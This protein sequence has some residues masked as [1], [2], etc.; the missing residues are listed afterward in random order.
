MISPL[1]LFLL[2]L[3]CIVAVVGLFRPFVGLLVF[4]A[5]H[6]V[7]PAEMLPALAPL[8]I[9]MVYAALLI[10]L[11][12]FRRRDAKERSPFF[13]DHV[14]RGAFV[15][16]GAAVLSVPFALWIGGALATVFELLK[17]I[18]LMVLIR[19]MVDTEDRLRG[20]LWCMT[21]IGAW[22]ASSSLSAF[23]N[24]NYYH[25][26]YNLGNLN[27]AQGVNSIVGG[28]NELAGALLALLPLLIALLSNTRSWLARLLLIVCGAVS[29]AAIALTGSRIAI[30]GLLVIGL[31][32]ACLSKHRVRVV[33]AIMLIGCSLWIWMPREYRQRYLTVEEYAEGAKLDDS[34]ELRFK[35]WAAGRDIF[36]QRPILGVGAGQFSTGYGLLILRGRHLAW[37][38]PHNL[39]IQVACELGLVGVF[40]FGYFLVQISKAIATVLRERDKSAVRMNYQVGLACTVMFVGVLTLSAA[41]HTL[42]RPYWYLLGGMVAAN[43]NLLRTKLKKASSG[44]SIDTVE[45]ES[46]ETFGHWNTTSKANGEI[47]SFIAQHER[48][49]RH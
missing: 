37:M 42:Y 49:R 41:G 1:I 36:L 33:L 31:F 15:L 44:Q 7:Q 12:T 10:G 48:R 2:L 47:S 35:I 22:F 14:L 32:Y 23:Y 3:A 9:E 38:Q 17:L 4:L 43:E 16:I 5:L 24:G 6:F 13:T 40:A 21:A 26:N 46:S 45:P 18:V 8:R 25:L 20:L 34:N 27:R 39:L 30:V 11:L 19:F 28:P 29:L